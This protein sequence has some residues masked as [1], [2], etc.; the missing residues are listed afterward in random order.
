[1]TIKPPLF[2]N[3]YA[4]LST[5]F[6]SPCQPTPVKKPRLIRFNHALADELGLQDLNPDQIHSVAVFAGNKM[7]Q[8]SE[9]I[10]AVY[11]GH[12]FGHFSHQLGDGRAILL[13][14]VITHDQM[15]Y[16]IQLKGSGRTPYSRG[17]DG[18][19]ALGPVLREYLLSE[20]MFKLGISTTRALA[21]VTTGEE[22]ARDNIVAGGI[23]TR[24]S[25][26]FVR[27]GTFEYFMAQGN[28]TAIKQL[29]DYEIK[30]HYP[31]AAQAEQPYMALFAAIVDR[32]AQLIASW[33]NIGFIH[34]VMNTDNMSI[35]G[36]TIDYGPCAFMDSFNHNQ[37]F[38]SIDRNARYAYGN[39]A[40]I[41][42]WNL[43]RLAEALLP[44][45]TIDTGNEDKDI[46][47]AVEVVKEILKNY[48]A[49][50]H[51]YWLIG[52]C[53]KL[54]LVEQDEQDEALI[55][56]LLDLMQHDQADF[57]LVFFNLSTYDPD[58][59]SNTISSLFIQQEA[60]IT[61]LQKWQQRT[62]QEKSNRDEQQQLMRSVNPVYI[63][64]NHQ[65]EA[66]IRAAEDHNDFSV[67][68]E[69]YDVLQNPYC[70]QEGKQHYHLAPQPDEVVQKT[71]C[72]T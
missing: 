66:A 27:V 61:W 62:Q 5:D 47:A 59:E 23:L 22:V 11:A 37:V 35:V 64:R 57:S 32:Q 18:R 30:Q 72:G 41:G 46:E 14:E 68:N 10:A 38:S 19:S 13:G 15:R 51:D 31:D 42:Q 48:E 58:S 52:M 25:K 20:T 63:P 40:R 43:T 16:S 67:F 65:I 6:F 28:Y 54:G 9:P 60:L 21:A 36:E 8:G 29:A 2:D 55:N 17:G 1:M 53:K 39:Q 45:I 50:Y 44:I 34:G 24:V 7:V 49:A 33:M 56:A 69:L 4:Q 26:G 71:F 70:F 12:Q 3:S